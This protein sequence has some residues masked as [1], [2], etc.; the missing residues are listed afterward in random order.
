MQAGMLFHALSRGRQGTDT[1]QTALFLPA[2]L[3]EATFVRAWQR[4]VER[5]PVLRSRFRWEG[6]PEPVQEVVNQARIPVETFD[7]RNLLEAE[8]HLKFR[9]LVDRDRDEGFDLG[10]APLVRLK[11]VRASENEHWI[12][13]TNH[14]SVYDGRGRVIVLQE[15]FAF[16]EAFS[17]GED[18]DIAPPRP[19]REY[20]EWLRTLDQDSAK[21]YWQT[22]LGG[23]KAPTPLTVAHELRAGDVTEIHRGSHEGRLNAALT[24]ALRERARE[25]SVT[26]NT[27][28]QGAWALMLHRYSGEKDVV[29]GATRACRRSALGG[30]EDM[31]GLFINTLPLRVQVDP[32]AELVP[33]LQQLRAQQLALR[34]YEHTPVVLVQSW[35]EVPRGTPLFESILVFENRTLD[36]QMRALGGAWTKRRFVRYHGRTNFPLTVAVYGDRELFLEILCSA[37][38]DE[39]VIA[40]M[41][42]HLQ[43]LLEGMA[44]NPKIKLRDLPLLT[45]PERRQLVVEWND[46]KT[47]YPREKCVHELFEAQAARTP[48]AVA[49][50]YEGHSVTYAKLN[51]RAN[52]LAHYLRAQGVGPE[53]MVGL[54]VERSLEM[55][56]GTLGILK[57]G[58]AY[59]P[60]DPDYPA[61]RLA[62]MLEDTQAPVLLTQGR[63]RERLPA[64]VG[65]VVA[66]DADWAEIARESEK[67][68]KVQVGAR[69]LAYV[70]YTS[71]STGRPKGTSIEHR[72]VV[73]LV[74]NTNY[75][76]LGPDEVF[77]QFA[78]ISFDASTLELWGPLLNGAR[79]VV[80]P[81]G[82]LSLEELGQVIRERGVTTLWLTAALFHQMVDT[83]IES[84]RGVRQLL[85]G[86][87][88]LSVP[89]VRRML[90]VIGNNRL[91]NGYG[92]TENTTFTCCYVMTADTRI[93][94][95]VP[96]GR[97]ISNSRVY[98]LDS[99][100]Q[101]VP[102]GV[103]GE[104]HIGG[105]GLA[106]E[107]LHQPQLT[108]EKFVPDPFGAE[109][110]ARLYKTG[111]RVRYL[112]DGNI[113][114]L[115]RVDNQVKI[116][117]YRIE[118]GE[119]EAALSTHPAV[120][121]AVV[122]ARED[123]PGEKRLVA[124][125]V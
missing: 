52:Q 94:H 71:G 92:P 30:A 108:E 117:G 73:R 57:A 87:E 41:L 118:L 23:F 102:V 98:V 109:P 77:L 24:A 111:D 50:E 25:A 40:R 76:E 115:G 32:D 18:L 43:M 107:Y 21:L 82:R 47:D 51:A 79:L 48:D 8:R 63:L 83:R 54:C 69:N 56:V 105:D 125:I 64:Y 7:W 121:E 2:R 45:D 4:V 29:F 15:V 19:Y 62:F 104:L 67:N 88:T 116:R 66:L 110:G 55:V 46:T 65:R 11:L 37:R 95:T 53:V 91:I 96:I 123:T 60:L 38:F 31:V 100:L 85:A 14:H 106:R 58:G 112:P 33:W 84:L 101:P 20:I 99:R 3:D 49:L 13:S 42:G 6:I 61:S 120:R 1:E 68:P 119:I 22:V 81:A 70:I 26:L 97:P 78:P 113:E 59:V 17:R 86:G 114:F 122:L 27:L 74:R 16:Y 34:D 72:S 44:A 12:L 36:E 9:A 39:N 80:C 90:E 35:S 75:I 93:G 103:Y 124:Y 28:V 10:E 5:H 89:H